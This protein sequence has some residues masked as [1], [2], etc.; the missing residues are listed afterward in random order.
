MPEAR[1]AANASDARPLEIVPTPEALAHAREAG[2]RYV[3]DLDP[4]IQRVRR[5]KGF[6][7]RDADGRAVRDA[8]VLK[9]IRSLVIPPAWTDV[10]ISPLANGHIQAT[11][12][13]AR[14]RKQYRY[15]ARWR[16]VRDES[17]FGRLVA[18][19]EALP[20]IRAR[21]ERDLALQGL[22]R[23]K[24]LATVVRLLETT[25]VRIGN[26]E[27]ARHNR[28]FGLTTMRDRHVDV[29][30]ATLRFTFR[31]KSGVP[32]QVKV[33]D[34]RLA[35]IV[36]ACQ[37]LPGQQLFQYQGDDG[38]VINIDS[39]DVNDYLREIAGAEF[40]AKDFRTWAGTVRMLVGLS[41]VAAE[42][43]AQDEPAEDSD[44]ARK[45]DLVAT[46]KAVAHT[47][48][49]TPAVARSSYIHPS[50]IDAWSAGTF[51]KDV[52]GSRAR[53]AK[54]TRGLDADEK[55]TVAF[56]RA[57]IRREARKP[58]LE[59]ALKK[60]VAKARKVAKAPVA[61]AGP[62]ARRAAGSSSAG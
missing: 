25:L 36:K 45:R 46:V 56:L 48:G 1:T 15:H 29:S 34:R 50:V 4:G 38:A 57:A 12:R 19:A 20:G 21:V 49:N 54:G 30:G 16:E 23:E 43:L 10:W 18:F 60:S 47:L 24:V 9:R 42:R 14:K 2:L 26:E 13:D 53:R 3:T 7:Y 58:S 51:A 11:G 59:Q 17:K 27:Y 33:S 8:A 35:R 39:S 28:S 5:G 61:K 41:K 22:P 62:P 37:D 55:A 40:T 52:A 44:A 32:H 6:G 31:G